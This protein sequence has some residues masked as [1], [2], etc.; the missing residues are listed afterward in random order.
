MRALFRTTALARARHVEFL[1]RSLLEPLRSMSLDAGRPW[2]TYWTTHALALMNESLTDDEKRRV[3][4]LL[5]R[6]QHPEGGF[7]GG[8]GVLAH[9]APSYAAMNALITLGGADALGIVDRYGQA[10]RP[11]ERIP[12]A[13]GPCLAYARLGLTRTS[14]GPAT[15]P[16]TSRVQACDARVAPTPAYGRRCFCDAY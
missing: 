7:G 6:C 11:P 5:A 8:P 9:L 16:A 2:M 15:T 10:T 1:R 14:P 4:D 3:V 13:R 12:P